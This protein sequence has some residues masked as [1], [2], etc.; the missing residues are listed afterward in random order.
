MMQYQTFLS[1]TGIGKLGEKDSWHYFLIKILV[2][3][4]IP[5]HL[6]M[7]LDLQNLKLMKKGGGLDT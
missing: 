2:K 5:L 7:I 6:M 1:L 4:W 3:Q